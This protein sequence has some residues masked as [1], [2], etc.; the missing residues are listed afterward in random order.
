MLK[1]MAS[2]VNGMFF[3]GLSI[4]MI[5]VTVP[6]SNDTLSTRFPFEHAQTSSSR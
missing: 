5:A 6:H 4:A 1:L 3:A 2:P